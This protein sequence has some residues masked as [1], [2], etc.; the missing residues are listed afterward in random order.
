MFKYD[1][2]RWFDHGIQKNNTNNLGISNWI[3]WSS[4]RMTGAF[5]RN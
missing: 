5:K 2:I 1:V 3:P 4:H